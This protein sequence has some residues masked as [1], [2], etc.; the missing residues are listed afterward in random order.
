MTDP[1]GVEPIW[2]G[3]KI[4]QVEDEFLNVIWNAVRVVEY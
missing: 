1:G 4:K 3:Y 2:F